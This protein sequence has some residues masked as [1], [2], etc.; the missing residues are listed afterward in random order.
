MAESLSKNCETLS[1]SGPRARCR[2]DEAGEFTSPARGG[3]RPSPENRQSLSD[4]CSGSEEGAAARIRERLAAAG[5]AAP[6]HADAVLIDLADDPP[7]GMS[8]RAIAEEEAERVVAAV[9]A[10]ML[11]TRAVRGVIAVRERSAERA[12]QRALDTLDAGARSAKRAVAVVR[13]ADVWPSIGIDRDLGLAGSWVL[14]GE[15]ALDLEAAAF[16]RPRAARRITVAGSVHRPSVVLG[17]PTVAEAV[18]AAGG[19]L[20]LGWV[21]LDGGAL[22]GRLADPDETIRSPLLLVLPATHA[23]VARARTSVSDWLRRAA[24]ACEGCRACSDV[25]PVLLDGGALVPHEAILT[26]VSGRDDG[27]R[28]AAAAS[29]ESCGVCDSVCPSALSPFALVGAVKARLP[30]TVAAAPRGPSHPDRR[31]RRMSVDLLRLRLGL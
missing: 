7:L 15:R 6:L 11:A 2:R 30:S 24:S 18:E 29:C 14:D 23:L 27:T 16:V 1:V 4:F 3:Q 17:S 28:L 20:D 19:A 25:C 12:I 5:I 10:A 26:L 9:G 13:V 8:A 31:G 22:G 21:A